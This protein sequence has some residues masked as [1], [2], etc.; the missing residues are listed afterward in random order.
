MINLMPRLNPRKLIALAPTAGMFLLMAGSVFAQQPLLNPNANSVVNPNAD[1]SAAPNFIVNL[2]LSAGALLAVMYLMYGGIRWITSRGD[3]MA[4]DAAK[5]H[6]TAAII[7]L[8]IVMGAF[9][10]INNVFTLLKVDN[11]LNKGLKK[12]GE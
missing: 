6:I 11:P 3:K 8:V 12:F 7:G 2:L 1:I 9:F 5:K 4:V 10:L